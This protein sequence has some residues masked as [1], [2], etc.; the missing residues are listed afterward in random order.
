MYVRTWELC[1]YKMQRC[2]LHHKL[3]NVMLTEVSY[4]QVSGRED[5]R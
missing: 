5:T 3:V 4:L 2:G 1:L